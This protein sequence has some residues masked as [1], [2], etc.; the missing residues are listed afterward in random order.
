MRQVWY[1]AD[2]PDGFT[3][4]WIAWK[5]YS[6][7]KFV[8]VKYQEPPPPYSPDDGILILDFS[9]PDEVLAKIKSEVRL[10]EVL[11]H[12]KTAEHVAK[13]GIFD[14]TK[15]GAR[16]T[17][18]WFNHYAYVPDFVKYIE[19]RDL[20]KWAL[21]DS[22]EINAFIGSYDFTFENWDHISTNWNFESFRQQGEAILRAKNRY[23]Q[24]ILSNIRPFKI[25]NDDTWYWAVNS[26]IFQSELGH[27]LAQRNA[28][29]M[30]HPFYDD[31]PKPIIVQAGIGVVYWATLTG[32]SYFLRSI[33]DID[34]SKIAKK[35]G[36]GGHKN[37]AGFK[38]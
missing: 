22:Q 23:I 38:L 24:T 15:S 29:L 14:I 25:P 26:P 11:D 10:L 33:G 13:Y 34:V 27:E 6:D 12:H 9:Y 18:E 1:H 37:A 35:Y 3:A 5:I 17:W 28:H 2:C 4:A 7:A 30:P 8:A 20:W 21:H 31:E 16:L 36:G 32:R 19:D